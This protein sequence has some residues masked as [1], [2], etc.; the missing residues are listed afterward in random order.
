MSHCFEFNNS[1]LVSLLKQKRINLAGAPTTIAYD[2]T[3]F[4]T[5]APAATMAPLPLFT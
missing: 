1:C 3:F 4:V 5:T 2:G